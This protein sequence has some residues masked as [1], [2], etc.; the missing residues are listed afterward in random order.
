[1]P[2]LKN[3]F[4]LGKCGF[5]LIQYMAMGKPTIST[6]FEANKKIDRAGINFF[7]ETNLD[8]ANCFREVQKQLLTIDYRH[9]REV[10]ELY[11]DAKTNEATYRSLFEKQFNA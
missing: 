2:L 10:I 9:N 8:W 1:M 5:K 11:Y 6:P 3:D 7:A 4:N